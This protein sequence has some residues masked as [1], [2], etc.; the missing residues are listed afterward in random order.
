MP[1]NPFYQ[2]WVGQ[3]RQRCRRNRWD[4]DGKS[5]TRSCFQ[6][7]KV[8]LIKSRQKTHPLSFSNGFSRRGAPIWLQ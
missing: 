4:I 2:P 5:A 7:L 1:A 6:G 8:H 3:I